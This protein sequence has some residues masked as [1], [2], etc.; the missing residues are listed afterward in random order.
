MAATSHCHLQ[1][2]KNSNQRP[3]NCIQHEHS[4]PCFQAISK[5]NEIEKRYCITNHG[6]LQLC[7][8]LV[9]W[10]R[11]FHVY[12]APITRQAVITWPQHQASVIEY[13]LVT[14]ISTP[15]WLFKKLAPGKAPALQAWEGEISKGAG[16]TGPLVFNCGRGSTCGSVHD[17]DKADGPQVPQDVAF[18]QQD[19]VRAELSVLKSR[20]L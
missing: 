17:L 20:N 4:S 6:L 2:H 13:L 16:F 18:M 5:Q 14:C 19:K 7:M 1:Q 3:F 9:N 8:Y 12:A 10:L 15:P 11:Q